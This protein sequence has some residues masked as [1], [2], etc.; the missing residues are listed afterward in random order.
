MNNSPVR[1]PRPI[2]TVAAE[3]GA[4]LGLYLILL[5]VFSGLSSKFALATLLVWVGT[6]GLPFYLYR[7]MRSHYVE[8]GFGLSVVELWSQA[9]LSFMLG[10]LL[11]A[12]AVYVLLRFAA[13]NF[14]A[15]QLQTAIDIFE[16]LGTP[17]GDNYA[18]ALV[19]H[20]ATF[21]VPTASQMAANLI[22]LNTFCGAV[23]GLADAIILYARYRS[24]ERRQ[25]A[26]SGP[27]TPQ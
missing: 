7:L 2:I 8:T 6:I 3:N 16:S 19:E 13:P 22:L 24:P 14:M 23:L 25:R 17:T 15:E 27:Q 12:V 5:A 26:G 21:G 4:T 10:S 18:R 1:P 11:Q 20:R 9:V